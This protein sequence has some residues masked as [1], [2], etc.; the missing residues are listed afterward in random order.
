ME[1]KFHFHPLSLSLHSQQ[2]FQWKPLITF[3][4]EWKLNATRCSNEFG[5]VGRHRQA[6]FV[7]SSSSSCV[8]VRRYPRHRSF[9]DGM[10]IPNSITLICESKSINAI[11]YFCFHLFVSTEKKICPSLT[12]SKHLHMP[13]VA[14]NFHINTK[15]K[16][17]QIQLCTAIDL[18]TLWC[19][20]SMS[21]YC[22][23]RVRNTRWKMIPIWWT[24]DTDGD[25]LNMKSVRVTVAKLLRWKP[26]GR[27]NN[28][29]K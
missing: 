13:Q 9:S 16:Y 25:A 18:L 7:F 24:P 4:S 11:H 1:L 28:N 3:P 27:E 5:N 22:V 23:V 12:S 21:I 26:N 29:D 8:E 20:S 2:R 10:A 17:L 19:V 14:I 6:I 15:R